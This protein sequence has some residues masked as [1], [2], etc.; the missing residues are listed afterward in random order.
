[1]SLKRRAF[2]L[3]R[4]DYLSLL[5]SSSALSVHRQHCSAG[6]LLHWRPL[7]EFILSKNRVFTITVN[8][9]AKNYIHLNGLSSSCTFASC[10]KQ[11]VQQAPGKLGNSRHWLHGTFS[12]RFAMAIS[13]DE[14]IAQRTISRMYMPDRVGCSGDLSPSTALRPRLL[15]SAAAHRR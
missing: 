7:Q 6:D 8:E 12:I 9:T 3:I 13:P 14:S 4:T 10:L 2:L 1:M 5:P 15:L 11:Y